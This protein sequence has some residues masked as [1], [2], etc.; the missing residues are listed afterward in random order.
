MKRRPHL[1]IKPQ[2]KRIKNDQINGKLGFTLLKAPS[3]RRP[4]SQISVFLICANR[5]VVTPRLARQWFF[6]ETGGVLTLCF[7]FCS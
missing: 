7:V 6:A 1:R 2:G 3:P 4:E 5:L